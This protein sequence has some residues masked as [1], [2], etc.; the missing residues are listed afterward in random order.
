[1]S[2]ALGPREAFTEEKVS[3]LVPERS[4]RQ[5]GKGK[6]LRA[7]ELASAKAL[8]HQSGY[9]ACRATVR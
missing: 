5:E 4:A 1:M 3:E 2:S 7:E 6:A 8:G 9:V